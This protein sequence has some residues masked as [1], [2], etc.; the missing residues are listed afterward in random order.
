MVGLVRY[1]YQ[2]FDEEQ[3]MVAGMEGLAPILARE[4]GSPEALEGWQLSALD[5]EDVAGVDRPRRP[6]GNMIGAA[7]AH[8][9][10]FLIADQVAPMRDPDQQFSNPSAYTWYHRD[11]SGGPAF[12]R[13]E[14][15]LRTVN[16]LEARGFALRLPYVFFKDYRWVFHED[17]PSIVARSWIS[18]RACTEGGGTCLEQSYSVD[19]FNG[20]AA[21]VRR[22]TATWSEATTQVELPENLLV[23][24]MVDSMQ[25]VFVETDGYMAR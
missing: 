14:G 21:G 13:G 3:A 22:L 15:V 19:V 9:S 6:L 25:T 1:L 23:A 24:A 20:H 7:A 5:R 4:A 18:D 10:P 16:D 2:H 8:N 12:A 11:A 17:G